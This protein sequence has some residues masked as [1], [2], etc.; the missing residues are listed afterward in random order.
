MILIENRSQELENSCVLRYIQNP[1]KWILYFIFLIPSFALA[2]LKEAYFAGGCFWSLE[3]R[4]EAEKGVKEVVSGYSGGK[5]ENPTY[6]DVKSNTTGHV[7]AVKVVYDPNA[8]SYERL[9]EIYW[10]QIDPTDEKGQFVDRGD[11]YR[12]VIF[13]SNPAEK[14]LAKASKEFVKSSK[15]FKK[16][17]QVGVESL[18]N[19]Y[20]AESY[21]Q[22]YYKNNPERYSRYREHSGRDSFLNESWKEF[23]LE[24]GRAPSSENPSSKKSGST[25]MKSFK[26]P[27]T[28]D[29]QSKLTPLQY[30]VT[31]KDGTEP[32]FQN[33]YNDNKR[34]GI[35]VDV[36]SGEPLFSSKDKFDSGTGWP[37]FTKPIDQ[38]AVVEK[39]DHSS[40]RGVRTEVR[41][42]VADS[43]LGHVFPDGPGP[44]G[45][46]YCMNSASLRFIPKED[47]E[48]EGYGEY[49]KLFD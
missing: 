12:P 11:S 40:I 28:K 14:E 21:H 18:K 48:K 20:P 16:P 3:A 31:Q 15:R 41:S 43:H 9:L 22:D 17:I 26:K 7:E 24:C 38:S 1:M 42:K 33:E 8:I 5:K 29:L 30:E 39:E 36:V 2:E 27:D 46:R 47:M 4:F 6:D 45:L 10:K 37:S 44:N 49:L 23:K 19:F 34:D 25:N 13:Y 32:P 35:Y